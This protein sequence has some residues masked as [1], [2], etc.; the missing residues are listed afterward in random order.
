MVRT[1][2]SW[3]ETVDGVPV[4][5]RS[6][7]DLSFLVRWGRVFSVFDQQD[8]GNLCFGLNEPSGRRHGRGVA[9]QLGPGP[10][11]PGALMRLPVPG[12]RGWLD[13]HPA[14]AASTP[15]RCSSGA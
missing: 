3:T 15:A 8:S 12:G 6:A 4:R 11:T 5:L 13:G 2:S 7:D 1:D 14:V 10:P 9:G